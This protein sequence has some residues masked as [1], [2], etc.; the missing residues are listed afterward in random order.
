MNLI[1]KF[2]KNILIFGIL[3]LTLTQVKGV[4]A[5]LSD[6]GVK[7]GAYNFGVVNNTIYEEIDGLSKRDIGVEIDSTTP[8]YVRVKVCIPNIINISNG[9]E[10]S[11]IIVE[12]DEINNWTYDET[13]GYYYYNDIVES[14]PNNLKLYDEISYNLEDFEDIDELDLRNMNILIYVESIQASNLGEDIGNAK[15]AFEL[16]TRFCD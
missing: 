5:Y 14:G 11:P 4:L 7:S 15:D 3:I 9:K 8:T 6:S 2:I 1:S 13:D 16:V 10:I 12:S